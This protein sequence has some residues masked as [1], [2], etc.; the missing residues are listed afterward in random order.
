LNKLVKR[1]R[2]RTYR[3]RD[4]SNKRERGFISLRV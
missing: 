3:D 4:W 2:A 1:N